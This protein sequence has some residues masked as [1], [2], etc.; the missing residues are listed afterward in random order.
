[1]RRPGRRWAAALCR[2]PAPDPRLR[3]RHGPLGQDR[4]ARRGGDRPFRRARASTSTPLP[5]PERVHLAELVGRRR[6]IIEMIGVET[7]IA[8]DASSGMPRRGPSRTRA[9]HRQWLLAARRPSRAFKSTSSSF[10]LCPLS[11]CRSE[12]RSAP[13]CLRASRPSAPACRSACGS[14][15]A[16]K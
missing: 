3:P 16:C 7:S 9:R 15:R 13:S 2:Q 4:H 5:E 14:I 10:Q 12:S 8:D 1:M 6:Q 11:A